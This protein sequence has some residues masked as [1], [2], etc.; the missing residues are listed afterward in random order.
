M[1]PVEES[2]TLH[3]STLASRRL[4]SLATWCR[5]TF[6]EIVKQLGEMSATEAG[7]FEPLGV[8]QGNR[9]Q[10]YPIAPLEGGDLQGGEQGEEDGGGGG[11][12]EWGGAAGG[13]E[14]T[15]ICDDVLLMIRKASWSCTG[16]GTS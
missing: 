13:G 6:E 12:Q 1:Q 16:G 8:W 7:S 3:P 2:V 15:A 9:S 5:P 10:P 11:E 4:S 14:E